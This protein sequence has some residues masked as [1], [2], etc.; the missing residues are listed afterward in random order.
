M[1]RADDLLEEAAK[2]GLRFIGPYAGVGAKT[3]YACEAHGQIAQTPNKVQQGIGCPKCGRLKQF[4]SRR[5]PLSELREEAARVGLEY[6]SGY[7]SAHAPASYR[8]AIHGVIKMPPLTVQK[9]CRCQRCA[10]ADVGAKRRKPKPEKIKL[11]EARVSVETLKSRAAC[12][13][14]R[15]EGEYARSHDLAKYI[16]EDHGEITM[17]PA[18]VRRGGGCQFCAGNVPKTEQALRDEA[19]IIGLEFIGPYFGDRK[20]TAY[21]CAKHGVIQKSPGDVKQGSFCRK[22]AKFGFDPVAPAKFYVY[23]VDRLIDGPFVG[24]GLTKDH[25]T[26][27]AAHM[28]V[29]RRIR[30]VGEL[31]AILDLPTGRDAADLEMH[32][33]REMADSHIRTTIRGF[34]TEAILAGDEPRLIAVI[35]RWMASNSFLLR[36][37]N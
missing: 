21:R 35:S 25:K 12:V 36:A 28:A 34:L 33:R 29:F 8:C 13:G 14:L 31:A 17:R 23:R 10:M 22:C 18:V 3:A 32:V 6:L 5:R 27:H 24:Y 9:G 30:A 7:T 2:V 26:R 4:A 1:K 15:Y 19:A 37:E 16:C 11:R 20:A